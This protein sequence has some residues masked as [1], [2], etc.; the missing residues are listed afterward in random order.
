M[1]K[2]AADNLSLIIQHFCLE[3]GQICETALHRP[4]CIDSTQFRAGYGALSV[5]LFAIF[6]VIFTNNE[7]FLLNKR[8]CAKV[9]R[10]LLMHWFVYF[11]SKRLSSRRANCRKFFQCNDLQLCIGVERVSLKCESAELLKCGSDHH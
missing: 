3:N 4:N 5:L 10:T 7:T 9:C 11:I 6:K 1:I 2:I 8:R